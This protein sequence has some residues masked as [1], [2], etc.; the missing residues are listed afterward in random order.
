MSA[1]VRDAIH[2]LIEFEPREWAV[3][4]SLPFQRLRGVQ[5]LAMTHL[6]Y[7]GA[8]HSRWE[9]CVGAAHLAGRVAERI[10]LEPKERE[11]V[12]MAA[13]THDIGHGPF[14]HVSEEVFEQRTGQDKVH[15]KISG[16]IVR[17]HPV[18]REEIG[19]EMS[20]WV[21]DLLCGAGHGERRS[22]ERDIVA[23]PADVDKLDYLLRD[24]HYC[25]V[26]YGEYDLHKIIETTRKVVPRFGDETYLGFSH[27]GVYPLEEM[28]LAR[29]HMHRQVYGHRTRMA[30][31]RM[32]VRSMQLGIDEGL[33]PHDVFSPPEEMNVEFVNSYIKWNDPRVIRTLVEKADSQA[34]DVMR[35]LIE[36]RLFKRLLQFTFEDLVEVFDRANAG[37][38]ARPRPQVLRDNLAEAERIVA[39]ALNVDPIWVS[40]HWV[41]LQNPL[42]SRFSFEL[43][44]KDILLVDD[45]GHA[46]GEFNAVSE[47]FSDTEL[48][49]KMLVTLYALLPDG[50]RFEDRAEGDRQ[51]VRQAVVEALGVIANAEAV[52]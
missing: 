15:E 44:G 34:G 1:E 31:D 11:Y 51:R 32:L 29:Y 18:L 7:P 37:D 50:G 19:E 22:V 3:I 46:T 2:G 17:H 14:S 12:R 42:G 35:A 45:E 5:Q 13:L 49:G 10:G 21:A 23:G 30:T 24:S 26:K 9:H 4:D 41:E 27:A 8:R 52:L 43:A 33:L 48:G 39:E 20:E 40:L 25:G 6:V 47:V 38:V 16:A 28:L 36:R